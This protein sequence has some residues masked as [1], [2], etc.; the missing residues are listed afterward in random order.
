MTFMEPARLASV[1]GEALRDG[2]DVG[3]AYVFGSVARGEA[4]A[5]SDLDVAVLGDAPFSLQRLGELAE[6]LARATGRDRVD[7]VDLAIAPPLVQAEVVRE[8][9]LALDRDRERRFDFELNAI[10]RYEDT[11]RLR[12]VQQELL[13]E[14]AGGR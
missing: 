8:G 4:S 10:R 3:L 9:L 6:R 2:D 12:A 11:R 1:V 7:L 5:G 14:A 13:R